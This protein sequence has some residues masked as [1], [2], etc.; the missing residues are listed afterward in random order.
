MLLENVI[1]FWNLIFY[2]MKGE[3]QLNRWCVKGHYMQ[4]LYH[5]KKKIILIW[6]NMTKASYKSDTWFKSYGHNVS[7]FQVY[8]GSR[9][10]D[11]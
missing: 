11:H 2:G 1:E 8:G 4:N 10:L 7:G 3:G 6:I 9:D 5:T